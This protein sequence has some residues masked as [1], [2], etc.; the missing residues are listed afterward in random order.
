MNAKRQKEQQTFRVGD[1]AVYPAHGVGKIE[2]IEEKQVG[3][4]KQAFYVMRIIETNMV[5]MIPLVSCDSVGLRS[6][7]PSSEVDKVYNILMDDDIELPSQPW[8]QRYR[9]YMERIRSGSVF[10]IATVLRDLYLLR[11]DKAL[12]F[13]E[14]KMM[15]T[16]RNLIVKELSIANKV[17]EDD[18]R[19]RIDRIFS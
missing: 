11:A 12:S 10:K 18:I 17:A 7:I 1:M 5:V 3:D 8:N 14:R 13:G 9:D 16:A 2:A 4:C 6:I 19:H 15:D